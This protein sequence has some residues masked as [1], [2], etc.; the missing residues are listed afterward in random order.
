MVLDVL[1][2]IAVGRT[3]GHRPDRPHAAVRFVAAALVEE[4]LARSSSVPASSEPTITVEAPAAS[5]LAISPL[6]RIPPSAITGT[7]AFDAIRAAS[8]IA[9]A[10]GLRFRQ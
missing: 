4:G 6:V 5:A 8:R 1:L 3:A 10:A 2:E 7:P 9:G